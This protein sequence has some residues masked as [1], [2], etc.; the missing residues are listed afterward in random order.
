MPRFIIRSTTPI[1]A[2]GTAALLAATGASTSC[3][4]GG[5]APGPGGRGGPREAVNVRAVKVQRISVQ[6]QVDMSG[7]LLSLDQAKVSSEVAGVVRS[8]PIQ[9]GTEVRPGDVLVQLDQRE[10]QFALDRAE[11]SLRQ[12]EA[13]LGMKPGQ[14]VP[15][16]DDQVAS[17]RSASAT[18]D[19]ARNNLER[20]TRLAGRGLLASVELEN[21]TSKL[22]V[23][24]ATYQQTFDSARSLK[25]SLL[26]RRASYELARKK[27]ADAS[28]RAPVAGIVSDRLVQPGEYIQINTVVAVVVQ[29]NPLKLRTALQERYAGLIAP[30]LPVEFRVETFPS[31]RFQGELAYVSPAV[32]QATRTFVVEALV[33]NKARRLKPGFFAKG[34]LTTKL[35]TNVPA[36]S[37]DAVATLAG[38]SSVYVVE[39]GKIR[40]QQV[41]LG[42]KQD[43]LYEVVDG[44]TGNELLAASSLSNL[45]TGTPVRVGDGERGGGGGAAG[46]RRG[47]GGGRRGQRGGQQ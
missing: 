23:A 9:I 7:T 35:D 18:R 25:A 44:L 16:D 40:Q 37:E 36:V 33:D 11:S 30:K 46:G 34:V 39:N 24:E 2:F 6:R 21:A 32:D 43:K 28:V 13:Q 29:I 8:V 45:A 15:P 12:T 4:R 3:S 22:K 5:A 20:V 38:V 1:V 10:L 14:A 27:L 41:T 47:Q 31:E 19:D 26:D 17:V 42:V